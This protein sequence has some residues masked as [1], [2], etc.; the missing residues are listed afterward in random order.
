MTLA[1]SERSDARSVS[2][3]I[4]EAQQSG[5]WPSPIMR[6]KF[7][8]RSARKLAGRIIPAEKRRGRPIGT[9]VE[10]LVELFR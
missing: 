7:Q 9:K 4:P 1:E 5:I 8:K 10:A 6:P 2:G 3:I